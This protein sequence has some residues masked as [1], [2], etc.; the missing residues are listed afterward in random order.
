MGK[1]KCQK[2]GQDEAQIQHKISTL[3]LPEEK[4]RPQNASPAGVYIV[5]GYHELGEAVLN[6]VKEINPQKRD[7]ELAAVQM[8]ERE[9][10]ALKLKV[11]AVYQKGDTL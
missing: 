7:K 10:N 11:E 4:W 5:V 2:R 6:K 9:E 3:R 1:H 8:K